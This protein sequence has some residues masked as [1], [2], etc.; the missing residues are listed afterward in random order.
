MLSCNLVWRAESLGQREEKALCVYLDDQRIKKLLTGKFVTNYFCFIV[1]LVMPNISYV[2][3]K[4]IS[5]HSIC[6]TACVLLAEAG[7]EGWYMKIR[8]CW[9]SDCY[10]VYIRNTNHIAPLHNDALRLAN[11]TLAKTAITITSL[12][13]VLKESDVLDSVNYTIEDVN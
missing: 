2:E 13:N 1:Q 12:R 7:K 3:L 8:L 6:V 9:L 10:E 5:T 11:K 4:R